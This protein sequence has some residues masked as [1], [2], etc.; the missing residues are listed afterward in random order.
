MTVTVPVIETDRLIL[1]EIRESEFEAYAAF[2]QSER[3]HLRGGPLGR[4]EAWAAFASEIGHWQL[5]GYGFWALEEKESGDCCGLVGLYYPEGWP[6]PEVG[7]LVWEA[8]E[9]KGI[10]REAAIRA[11]DYAYQTLGWERLVSCISE[12]NE[13]SVQL[14]K[15][16][17]ATLDRR[18]TRAGRPDLLVYLHPANDAL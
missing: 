7:W 14:A 2:Y 13:R 1:R 3:S 8:Y 11:R 16:L 5:R 9:G 4:E 10:A 18:V 15:R 17:G 12:G 6:E